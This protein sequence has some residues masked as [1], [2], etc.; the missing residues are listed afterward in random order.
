MDSMVFPVPEARGT[1]LEALQ[2]QYSCQTGAEFHPSSIV[3]GIIWS[4]P[5]RRKAARWIDPSALGGMQAIN[6]GYCVDLLAPSRIENGS[7]TNPAITSTYRGIEN[8][9]VRLFD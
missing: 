3:F 4:D 8:G 9:Y 1:L 6:L 5:S 7:V 2:P